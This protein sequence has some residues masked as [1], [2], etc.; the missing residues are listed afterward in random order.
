MDAG[1]TYLFLAK[2]APDGG[3]NTG[4]GVRTWGG[5]MT[6]GGGITISNQDSSLSFRGMTLASD[7][8][9]LV[10][11]T[12]TTSVGTDF[13][14]VEY[15]P[16]GGWVTSASLNNS[17]SDQARGIAIVGTD[18]LIVGSTTTAQTSSD[19]ALARFAPDGNGGWSAQGI[20]TS[21]MGSLDDQ[22]VLGMGV[23]HDGGMVLAGVSSG[24]G[25]TSIITLTRVDANGNLDLSFGGLGMGIA[26]PDLP[27]VA[28]IYGIAVDSSDDILLTGIAASGGIFVAR[29]L[30]DGTV[31]GSFGESGVA[32]CPDALAT[33]AMAVA[34]DQATG[35]IDV[36]G[37]VYAEDGAD[38][39]LFQLGSSGTWTTLT[40]DFTGFD[41]ASAILIDGNNV[42]LGGG[43]SGSLARWTHGSDGDSY[44]VTG[45][46]SDGMIL[47]LTKDG[48]DIIA[49]GSGDD[50]SGAEGVAVARY[51]NGE[52]AASSVTP[53]GATYSAGTAVGVDALGNIVV[54][55]SSMDDSGD[56]SFM[57]ARFTSGLVLDTTFNG[58]GYNLTTQGTNDSAVGLAIQASGRIVAGGTTANANGGDYLFA[59]YEGAAVA[60][61][62][63]VVPAIKAAMTVEFNGTVA[64]FTDANP[65]AVAGDF[66]ATIDWGDGD[67]TATYSI[68]PD[69]SVPGQF[70]VIAAKSN[71]YAEMGRETIVVTVNDV[72]GSL[73]TAT[74]TFK[75]ADAP[76][77]AS[78]LSIAAI[79]GQPFADVTVAAFSD[80][81]VN[82]LAS[83]F[84]ATIKWGDG[85]QS[86]G[87]VTPFGDAG[88]FIVKGSH[89]YAEE[90]TFAVRVHIVDIDGPS[91]TAR[92]TAVVVDAP[93][94]AEPADVSGVEGQTF[95]GVVAAF[96]DA[97]PNGTV[98]DYRATITWGDGAKTTGTVTL[99]DDTG[100]FEV[101][102]T[103]VYKHA[104]S[105]AVTVSIADKGGATAS[106]G[107]T[108]AIDD[109]QIIATGTA[110]SATEGKTF[111]GVVATFIDAN[112]YAV[113]S[114]YS[115]SI[116]WSDGHVSAG[117]VTA[118]TGGGF[119]VS[120][121]NTYAEEGSYIISVTIRDD[122]G[123][124]ATCDTAANVKD[125]PL[126]AFGKTISTV[127]GQS[128]N[129][130]VASFKDGNPGSTADDF[131][132]TIDWGD[133]TISTGTIVWNATTGRYDVSSANTYIMAGSYAVQVS[134]QEKTGSG[135]ASAGST[136]KVA[137]APLT[138]AAGG[139]NATANAAFTGVVATFTDANPYG[140]AS[141][142]VATIKWGD[143]Q[144]SNGTVVADEQGE[145]GSFIV[146]GTNT[147]TAKGTRTYTVTIQD[148]GGKSTTATGHAIVQP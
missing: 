56:S 147:Y 22:A 30:P 60:P 11:A 64:T 82:G 58:T 21:G 98:T 80:G 32:T 47:A 148:V 6:V 120:G 109:A 20:V 125:A 96:T 39:A 144:I 141:D 46:G 55:G 25:N 105:F 92:S 43:S 127:E 13:G 5:V 118:N 8:D 54:G 113:A 28:L 59:G 66:T 71:P 75:V 135:T 57:V 134:I 111:S 116:D 85:S 50:A 126:T 68:Q 72:D 53:I 74:R 33:S 136:A 91:A 51:T 94:N 145:P 115:A 40:H 108:A 142:Y 38:M 73:A 88:D 17:P 123:A 7:G 63:V 29:L 131:T 26:M 19:F 18:A 16:S 87:V 31:D 52:L 130:I 3:L 104:G 41:A 36:A 114:D 106:V 70:T 61:L 83:Q 140:Q 15:A 69:T 117:T 1:G 27:G 37:S 23:Q 124:T 84:T 128:Y 137:D 24:S 49:V 79:E 45:T 110:V 76:I 4:F 139:I 107:T 81:D 101:A 129:G 34:Y 2:Y 119:K 14:L 133:G 78:G 10:A 67:T 132:A 48:P 77:T 97:D 100:L 95:S 90:K 35:N 62:H 42:I 103:H 99:D 86:A 93:L 12:Q 146:V 112:P 122:G 138:S 9:I 143:G 121:S 89:T 65:L 44:D 102:G